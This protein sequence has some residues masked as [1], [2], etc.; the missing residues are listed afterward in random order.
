M[1]S[2]RFDRMLL[3]LHACRRIHTSTDYRMTCSNAEMVGLGMAA[4]SDLKL[5][6]NQVANQRKGWTVRDPIPWVDEAPAWRGR[7]SGYNVTSTRARLQARARGLRRGCGWRRELARIGT[8]AT[9]GAARRDVP[10]RDAYQQ[11]AIQT[12]HVC[13]W[14]AIWIRPLIRFFGRTH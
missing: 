7:A 12:N 9:S 10:V 14:L 2:N 3:W 11:H 8:G 1:R 6:K 4:H 13:S 5:K